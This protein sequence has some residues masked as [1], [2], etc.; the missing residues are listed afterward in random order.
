KP[1]SKPEPGSDASHLW[2]RA[3]T[4]A[5][6][7]VRNLRIPFPRA[8]I[9]RRDPY[10]LR[11]AALLLLVTGFA[12]AG[13]DWPHRLK[14]GL[15][16]I[17]ALMPEGLPKT[18]TLTFVPPAYTGQSQSV[19]SGP[20][21][22]RETLTLPIGTVMKATA[23]SSLGTPA[24][25][26]DDQS[27]RFTPQ[28][29]GSYTLEATITKGEKLGISRFGLP[30]MNVPISITPDNP[31]AVEAIAGEDG[32]PFTI[33]QDQTLRFALNAS[34]DYG[35]KDL[36]MDMKLD[37]MIGDPPPIGEAVSDIRAITSPKG[38]KPQRTDPVYDFTASPWAGLPA[39]VEFSVTDHAGQTGSMP[40]ITLTLPER[41]FRHPVSQALITQRK[42]LIWSPMGEPSGIVVALEALLANPKAFQDDQIAYLGIK[43]AAARLKYAYIFKNQSVPSSRSVVDLLWDT[44]LRIEDGNLSLAARNLRDAQ[45]ELENALRE[46]KL[47]KEEMMKLTDKVRELLQQYLSEMQ[48]ELQKRIQN[49]EQM[50]MIPPEMLSQRLDQDKLDSFMQQMLEEMTNGNTQKAQE[51]LS[52]LQKLL[53]SVNPSLAMPMPQDMQQ[54]DEGINEMQQLIERQEELLAQTKLQAESAEAPRKSLGNLQELL[55]LEPDMLEQLTAQIPEAEVNTQSN[56]IEQDALRFVLGQLMLDAGAVFKE[57]P[58]NLGMAEMEMRESADQLG[59]N[60]PRLS[61]PHQEDTIKLLKEAQQQMQKE[62]GERMQQMMSGAGA[63]MFFSMPSFG[64]RQLDPLG[65]PLNDDQ[66]GTPNSLYAPVEIPDE[67]E[68]QR[69]EEI[70][71]LLRDRSGELYRPADELDYFRRLLKQF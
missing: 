60:K 11:L 36:H 71:K 55:K 8:L 51:M 28:G 54:M 12:V 9:A 7:N 29:Q 67:A 53:D 39:I 62:L 48:E 25:T 46:N 14:A 34:D 70:Q 3:R 52:Q 2:K 31:P 43:V 58:R 27:F 4:R 6:D 22:M 69:A 38:G 5:L 45:R 50:P 59:Q 15:V 17:A 56:K 21:W 10:A 26:L 33:L 37:P 19:V 32:K 20:G 61:V 44:A 35:A 47:N 65:R 49:G 64:N 40:P 66:N 18:I 57:I 30:V 16:P 63:P 68:R 42:A 41:E 23:L 24:F 1:A 13:A